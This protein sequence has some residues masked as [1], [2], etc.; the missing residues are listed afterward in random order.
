MQVVSWVPCFSKICFLYLLCLNNLSLVNN[1]VYVCIFK[2]ILTT[3]KFHPSLFSK[4][5]GMLMFQ[6]IRINYQTMPHFC[7]IKCILFQKNALSMISKCNS[8][9][10]NKMHVRTAE[11]NQSQVCYKKPSTNLGTIL[12]V[13][14]YWV[15][16]C[17]CKRGLLLCVK[18]SQWRTPWTMKALKKTIPTA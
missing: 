18:L 4:P 17:T 5:P 3:E 6:I 10:C 15:I 9:F 7:F 1:Y 11:R 13:F 8:L 2:F 16:L 12:S 14:T